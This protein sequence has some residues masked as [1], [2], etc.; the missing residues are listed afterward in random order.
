ME[1]YRSKDQKQQRFDKLTGGSGSFERNRTSDLSSFVFGKV[2]PQALPLEE[3]VLGALM[4]DKDGLPAVMDILRPE[5]FYHE[6]HQAIYKSITELF[7]NSKPIDL[8]TVT[9]ELRKMG[10]V[11]LIGGS[12]YLVE[13]TNRVAS[14][15]NIEY[16]ARI[17]AQK[18]IQRELIKVSTSIIKDA[19]EDTT[20]IFDLLDK[21]EQS[22]FA[23]TET[24]LTRSFEAMSSLSSKLLKQIE[25]LSQ[26]AEGLTGIPTGFTELDRLT[27]G[28]Q[29]SDLVI[30]AARP[31][32]GKTAFTLSLAR[33]AAMEFGKG[34]ALF[35]LEMSNL[36]LVQRLVSM[37][38]EVSSSK[39]RTGQLEPHEWQQLHAAIEKMS[40]TPIFI[41]DTPGI[42]V[43]E[44][45]AK[46]RRLKAQH[47]I[48]LIIIDYL[49]L[50]TG[51]QDNHRGGNREQE[52]SSISR[53]L[54][55]LAKELNVPV[56][57]LSQL[58]RAVE[59]R[60][61][62]KKPQLSDLRE[63]G[64]IEQDADIV[65]FI[66][67]PEYYQIMEDENGNST[68]GMADIIVS[69]HRNGALGEV[70]LRFL[71][72]FSKFA[73]PDDFNFK[74]LADKVAARDDAAALVAAQQNII[75]R[76][77]RMNEDLVS[78]DIPF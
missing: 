52:I 21:A 55:G 7:R 14:A 50:M 13:L 31:S 44:L 40:K 69:K 77:S 64:A 63:S 9:E 26:R 76:S 66:Y 30:I 4:L 23:I 22:L 3:A 27:S 15:A 25:M 38:S 49:Q 48:Q 19:Y 73:D 12:Y 47:D 74:N 11:E 10:A 37:E 5:S 54:K 58:S 32:M 6:G 29:P 43:F 16:H 33:N 41:D 60:G 45:R 70:R 1:D 65:S 62:S 2:Q 53:A 36:Q 34:V 8:L 35:S 18:H 75:T 24:N 17:I 59:T 72:E 39:L 51:G 71:G 42:N 67:R 56:I 20:D 46:C 78:G 28:W 57:A 68:K 61:G